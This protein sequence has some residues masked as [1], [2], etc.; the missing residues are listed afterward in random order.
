MKVGDLVKY[1]S[2]DS[3]LG[4]FRRS[5][6]IVTAQNNNLFGTIVYW[7]RDKQR[8]EEQEKYLVVISESR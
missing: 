4:L 7:F 1:A 5:G 2:N 6:G 8:T 3:P